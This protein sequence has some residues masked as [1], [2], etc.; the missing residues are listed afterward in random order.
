ME[1]I[2]HL[3]R[4]CQKF[5]V[6]KQKTTK[7][8]RSCANDGGAK[9]IFPLLHTTC[10]QVKQVKAYDGPHGSL[11]SSLCGFFDCKWNTCHFWPARIWVWGCSM[12]LTPKWGQSPELLFQTSCRLRPASQR[13]CLVCTVKIPLFTED[14]VMFLDDSLD[15][16]A[17]AVL[18]KQGSWLN[19]TPQTDQPSP[20][21]RT[22][23]M[24]PFPTRL[25]TAATWRVSM[26]HNGFWF[27]KHD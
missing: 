26:F 6:C 22:A 21:K 3:S 10:T 9:V 7:R 1:V 16:G 14:F 25:K 2:S 19:E 11:Q 15:S 27:I 18:F 17:Q 12:A 4:C 20:F 24:I 13:W 23:Q 8:A 5:P